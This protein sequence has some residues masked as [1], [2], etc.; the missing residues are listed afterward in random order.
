MLVVYA[1]KH[2]TCL[3]QYTQSVNACVGA[4][5]HLFLAMILFLLCN[6]AHFKLY[7]NCICKGG[8]LTITPA[9]KRCPGYQRDESIISSQGNLTLTRLVQLVLASVCIFALQ[10]L[11]GTRGEL[12][13]QL[14]AAKKQ[15]EEQEARSAKKMEAVLASKRELQVSLCSP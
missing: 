12:A 13:K 14:S 3:Q 8:N 9:G 11:Q 7:P 4:L 6:F 2:A 10:K 5:F 15:L 1:K